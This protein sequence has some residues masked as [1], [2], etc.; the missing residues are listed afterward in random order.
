MARRV[1]ARPCA[2]VPLV[3]GCPSC[4][5]ALERKATYDLWDSLGVIAAALEAH[6]PTHYEGQTYIACQCGLVFNFV[7]AKAWHRHAAAMV[8]HA[9][10]PLDPPVVV[11]PT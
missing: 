10:A 1:A 11:V 2:H 3:S 7:D 8:L 5:R 4:F 9:V 6:L